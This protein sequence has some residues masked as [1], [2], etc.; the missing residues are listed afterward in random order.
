MPR[1]KV[2]LVVRRGSVESFSEKQRDG[3]A[4]M[5]IV[6][7]PVL[8]GRVSLVAKAVL[9]RLRYWCSSCSFS[10]EISRRGYLSRWVAVG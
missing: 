6:P 9:M 1:K 5:G 4:N 8:S 7:V 3:G 2:R 10:A